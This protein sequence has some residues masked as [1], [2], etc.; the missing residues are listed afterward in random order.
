MPAVI[1][2]LPVVGRRRE[3]PKPITAASLSLTSHR[4]ASPEQENKNAYPH[5]E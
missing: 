2:S 1:L 3:E 4:G 5:L